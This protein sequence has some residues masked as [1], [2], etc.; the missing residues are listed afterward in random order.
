M[1]VLYNCGGQ[2]LYYKEKKE[3]AGRYEKERTPPHRPQSCQTL[4]RRVNLNVWKGAYNC[5]NEVEGKEKSKENPL[6]LGLLL[7][8]EGERRTDL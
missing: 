1:V 2:W 3:M 7:L 5:L 4:S 8:I 6:P